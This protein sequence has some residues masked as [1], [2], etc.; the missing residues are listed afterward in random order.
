LDFSLS[1]EQPT[2]TNVCTWYGVPAGAAALTAPVPIAK[3][4]A[5]TDAFAVTDEGGQVSR[6][7]A[8]Q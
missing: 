7:D 2:E 1:A 4:C 6:P 3:A 8:R 5:N